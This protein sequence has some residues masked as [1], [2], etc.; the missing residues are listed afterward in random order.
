MPFTQTEWDTLRLH[1]AATT[2]DQAHVGSHTVTTVEGSQLQTLLKLGSPWGCKCTQ[3]NQ[4]F[5]V[6]QCKTVMNS[7]TTVLRCTPLRL[8]SSFTTDCRGAVFH[9]D[10]PICLVHFFLPATPSVVGAMGSSKGPSPSTHPSTSPTS[11]CAP[12]TSKTT[13]ARFSRT[14]SARKR[15]SSTSPPPHA[16]C[17]ARTCL[18]DHLILPP[19]PLVASKR[20]SERHPCRELVVHG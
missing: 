2:R 18:A 7:T 15:K 9:T 11:S 20:A 12:S 4:N 16:A 10:H 14:T 5:Y 13:R 8:R 17:S 1:H 6:A 19:L 3:K